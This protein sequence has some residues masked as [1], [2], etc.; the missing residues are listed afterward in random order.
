MNA[1]DLK[2]ILPNEKNIHWVKETIKK[3]ITQRRAEK[4]KFNNTRRKSEWGGKL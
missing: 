2:T 1:V 3:I 4:E